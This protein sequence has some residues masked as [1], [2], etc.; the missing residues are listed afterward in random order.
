[1]AAKKG[2]AFHPGGRREGSGRK[3]SEFVA[4][5]KQITS[6]PK[7][8]K[9]AEALLANE[10]TEEKVSMDG[11]VIMVRAT[12]TEKEKIWSALAAYGYGKPIQSVEHVGATPRMVLVFPEDPPKE[13]G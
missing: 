9:W 10:A 1:M 13:R 3:P 8:F 2:V 6:N 7:F 4:K 5:C 11:S 12:A